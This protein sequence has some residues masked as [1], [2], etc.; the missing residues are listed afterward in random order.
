MKKI[1]SIIMFVLL[2]A[3]ALTMVACDDT[4]KHNIIIE[5][6]VEATCTTPGLTEGKYCSKCFKATAVPQPVAPLGH[7]EVVDEAVAQTCTTKGLTEGKHC[8]TCGEIL[9][10]QEVVE[11]HFIVAG[12]AR[13]AT[14]TNKL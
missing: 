10:A 9:L 7:T 6:A 8:S 3:L 13:P 11:M 12:Q 14:C 2:I 1:T 5:E 4:C